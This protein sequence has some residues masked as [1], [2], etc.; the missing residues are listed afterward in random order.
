MH[1]HGLA[2]LGGVTPRINTP[3]LTRFPLM[4][5]HLLCLKG[6][7]GGA[8][9]SAARSRLPSPCPAAS[10]KAGCHLDAW[11]PAGACPGGAGGSR[12]RPRS[13]SATRSAQPQSAALAA[14]PGTGIRIS[15]EAAR[16]PPGAWVWGTSLGRSQHPPLPR[17]GQVPP[18]SRARATSLRC[19]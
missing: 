19:F 15:S 9:A 12:L 2:R 5:G 1:T 4:D 13:G 16:A 10:G 18:R 7:P 11:P 14:F 3:G 6:I 8:E 17:L